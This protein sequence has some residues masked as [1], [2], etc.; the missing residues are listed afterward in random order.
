MFDIVKRAL[1]I[2]VRRNR[3]GISF[4]IRSPFFPSMLLQT[5]CKSVLRFKISAGMLITLS[6]RLSRSNSQK[7]LRIQEMIIDRVL[8]EQLRIEHDIALMKFQLNSVE[9]WAKDHFQRMK[10]IGMFR[11]YEEIIDDFL[12]ILRSMITA[13]IIKFDCVMRCKPSLVVLSL[14]TR[15]SHNLADPFIGPMKSDVHFFLWGLIQSRR[16]AEWKS[17][18]NSWLRLNT[19]PFSNQLQIAYAGAGSG[20][21][22]GAADSGSDGGG[23]AAHTTDSDSKELQA[24]YD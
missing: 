7:F 5:S 8:S 10:C 21:A 3:N 9:R 13:Q 14:I 4:Q 20:A 19:R 6:Q 22:G 2:T 16:P 18:F 15:W 23:A 12:S 17:E 11:F 1:I 24:M